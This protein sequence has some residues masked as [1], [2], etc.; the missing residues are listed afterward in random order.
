MSRPR[1]DIAPRIVH[2]AR[3]RFLSEGVDGASLRQIAGEAGTSIGMI[4]YY[5]PTKDDLFL[6]VVEEVYVRLLADLER[7]LAPAAPVADR[8]RALYQRLGALS[9]DELL[10]L[11][12]VV[13]EVLVSPA[14]L[15]RLMER[16]RHGH[17]PLVLALV[18]DG[19]AGGTFDPRLPPALVVVAMMILAGPAQ[20]LLQHARDEIPLPLPPGH[21]VSEGLL[22]I[23][24]R[25]VSPPPAPA[26]RR[27]AGIRNKKRRASFS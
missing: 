5:F 18:R 14:R 22:G 11:R 25:G 4:Y 8:L 9:P 24:L 17:L 1:S 12:I 10:V 26:R 21:P 15:A 7:G 27:S 2:A 13:R 19:F 23:L 6:A 16:F 3:A 20:V